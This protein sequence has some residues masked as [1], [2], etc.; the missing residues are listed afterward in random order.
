M[1]WIVLY[2]LFFKLIYKYFSYD[3]KKGIR[4]GWGH[5]PRDAITFNKSNY[6][7]VLFII[8]K[9][10]NRAPYFNFSKSSTVKWS[11]RNCDFLSICSLMSVYNKVQRHIA[12]V[13][14]L[15]SLHHESIYCITYRWRYTIAL[16][17]CR[18]I[19]HIEK[20]WVLG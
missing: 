15:R 17:M 19:F 10:V 11:L 5:N 2:Y 16:Q 9:K 13:T 8:K 1:S 18:E 20:R 6:G 4:V 14:L 7:D 12:A 3:S